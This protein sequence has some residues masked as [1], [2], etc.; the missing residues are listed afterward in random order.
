MR[1]EDVTHLCFYRL[2]VHFLQQVKLNVTLVRTSGGR[3]KFFNC[4]LTASGAEDGCRFD[5]QTSIST[6]S[7]SVDRSNSVSGSQQEG[8]SNSSA[9]EPQQAQSSDQLKIKSG[10]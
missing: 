8:S 10:S 7:N 9:Q 3:P 6:P 2:F 4:A 5:D 1:I